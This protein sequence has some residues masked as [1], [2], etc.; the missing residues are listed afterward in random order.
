MQYEH[1]HNHKHELSLRK[2]PRVIR[3]LKHKVKYAQKNNH[4]GAFLLTSTSKSKLGGGGG[5]G[6]VTSSMCMKSLSKLVWRKHELRE[7]KMTD[8][9]LLCFSIPILTYFS[10]TRET[11]RSKR[12]GVNRSADRRIW[13]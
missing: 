4:F 9:I 11:R 7:E 13:P 8:K 10:F 2:F 1:K 5:G 3:H 6:V 12:R